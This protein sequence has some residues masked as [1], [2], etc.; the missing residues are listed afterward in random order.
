MRQKPVHVKK[1]DAQHGKAAACGHNATVKRIGRQDTLWALRALNLSY[2]ADL[3]MTY[4]QQWA[5]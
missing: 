5:L 3:I 1:M 2:A 4:T